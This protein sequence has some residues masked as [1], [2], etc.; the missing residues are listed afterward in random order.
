MGW[1]CLHNP[2]RR[3][4]NNQSF[5]CKKYY[6]TKNSK[7]LMM[8]MGMSFILVSQKILIECKFVLISYSFNTCSKPFEYLQE[9]IAWYKETLSETMKAIGEFLFCTLLA[10]CVSDLAGVLVYAG[11]WHSFSR[12]DVW[13]RYGSITTSVFTIVWVFC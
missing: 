9:L 11:F 8:L 12:I 5:T 6:Q 13:I 3:L 10:Y 1:L 4:K 2:T 7:I